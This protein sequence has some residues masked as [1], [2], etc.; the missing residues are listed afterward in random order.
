MNNAENTNKKVEVCIL[1]AGKGTRMKSSKPKVLHPI[2]GRPMLQH[3]VSTVQSLNVNKVHVVVGN[4]AEEVKHAFQHE[5]VNFVPQLEQNGTG[6]AVMQALPYFEE[7]NRVLILL[8]DAPL[9]KPSTIAEMLECECDLA[10][11]TVV[12]TNPFNYG[13]IIRTQDQIIEIV[14]EKDASPEQQQITEINTGVMIADVKKLT[15]WL[16]RITPENSQGELLLTDI[17]KMANLDG[18]IVKGIIATDAMEVQ[19]VND[20]TQLSQLERHYQSSIA[21]NLMQQGVHLMDPNRIDV[22]GDLS[23]GADSTIDINCIFEGAVSLGSNVRVG[24]NCKIIDSTIGDNV[25]VKPNS[26]IEG[27]SL[28][29]GCS[30]GPFVRLRPGAQ[31]GEDVAIGNFVEV[32]KTSM[33]KGSKASHLSYLGDALIGAG[34]NIGAGTITCN[35]DGVN[36]H[37]T[38]IQDDVFVGSNTALVAPVFVGEGSTIAA[39]STITK[40]I[41]ADTLAIGRGRQKNL[42]NW[43]GPRSK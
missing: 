6:H 22:R 33:G 1:A 36:K 7:S 9:L 34:V 41:D 14:E 26:I 3:L 19:G 27:A 43:K 37:I 11:L 38:E 13:R 24:A 35:Y 39:G 10:V 17:V 42:S 2:A 20:F 21:Q 8:G 32:K 40:K 12:Q 30:V 29:A 18:D 28:E 5:Q 15:G 4:G 23:V 31:L 25:E 16:E